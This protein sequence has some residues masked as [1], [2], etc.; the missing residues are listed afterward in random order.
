[1][2]ADLP[3]F[4]PGFR[5]GVS[6]SAY[7]IE[8][9]AT[10]GGR[11]PS[12]WDTFA[13][14]PGRVLDGSTGSVACDHYH[15]YAEDVR[16]LR[17]L[18]VD[19]YRFSFSWPR[20]QPAG[21]GAVNPEGL[22]F[23]DRLIDELLAA[24]IQPAP[25]LFHWDTPQPLED[26]GGWLER[27]ITERFAD[28]AA[29]LAERFA[30]R[31]GLW[32]TINEPMVLT[33]MGYAVG[34]HAPGRDLGFGAL[35]VAHH[36]LLAHG[37]AVQALRAGGAREIGIASNH[38]PTWAASE[39]AEDQ[40]AAALY[41][42]L[43]NWL[44]AD[45]VLLGRYPTDDLAAAMPGPVA[46]D[47]VVIST[48]LDFFGLN[49]YAPTLVGAP[50][51]NADT[52]ATDGIALPPGLPFEP[53]ALTGYAMTDFGWPVVPAAFGEILQT[54]R[55]RY[56]DRLPPLYVTENGCAINDGVVDGVV[57]DRR[58]ID[59]LDGYLRALK[60]A[61]DDGIDV[62]GYFQW[63]LLDNFEWAAGYTQRFGL[64]HVDFET[65]TRTP[66]A[67]YGWYR[68]LIAQSRR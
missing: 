42:T 16:L 25:T 12:V 8:G 23:Y 22:G 58:R 49:H 50:T 60:A 38:S 30:D 43:I 20:I 56:G 33:L 3:S 59:Y 54:L 24:G 36:Q 46:E 47:L 63:S 52:G 10:E 31:V 18:G 5:W 9:A 6:T 44:F 29:L 67:S 62:R 65:R 39:S 48:P 53:R 2:T 14:A 26:A 1:M 15:R 68:E 11:G 17:D 7:Q 61:I 32:M 35:P 19:T 27:D 41:D 37:R 57:D 4:G 13:G 66:K 64:V 45:P 40:E 28:Y 55:T 21:S 34:A 51:G